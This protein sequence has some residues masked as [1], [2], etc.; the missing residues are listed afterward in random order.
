MR[1]FAAG[2]LT[3]RQ[4]ESAANRL[5]ASRDRAIA[6]IWSVVW[7]FYDDLR[8]HRLAGKWRLP[9]ESR[10]AVARAIVFLHTE[11]PYEWPW[12]PRW[13]LL[14]NLL[15]LGVTAWLFPLTPSAGDRSVWPFFRRS[16][17]EA[18]L[19]RP[20]LLAGVP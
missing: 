14:I 15:T 11:L 12:L 6:S 13:R 16:D 17:Y 10:R 18:A 5:V 1:H 4:Y 9:P 2:R 20:R 8:V 7:R 3:N 19:A